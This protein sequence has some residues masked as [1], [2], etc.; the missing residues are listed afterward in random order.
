M[1]LGNL[2]QNNERSSTKVVFEKFIMESNERTRGKKLF[3]RLKTKFLWKVDF[4]RRTRLK[5]IEALD[6]LLS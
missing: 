6:Q 1:K 5:V 2:I 4:A 3:L